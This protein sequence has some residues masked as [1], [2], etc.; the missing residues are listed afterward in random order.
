M[1]IGEPLAIEVSIPVAVVPDTVVRFD[2]LERAVHWLTSIPLLVLLV[3]GSMLYIGPLSG[4]VRRDLLKEIHTVAGLA[5]PVPILLALLLRG[6]N[7][8]LRADLRR[9]AR[10]SRQDG[11]WV[12]SLGRRTY[13]RHPKFNGGQKLFAAVIAGAIPTMLMTGSLMRWPHA[14]SDSSRTGATFVHDWVYLL[15]AVLTVGHILKALAAPGGLKPMVSGRV[16]RAQ[17]RRHWPAWLAEVEPGEDASEAS[18]Q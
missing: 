15:L 6:R 7:R 16:T 18:G 4:I 8:A 10:W 13:A 17:A 2:G 5:L 1:S 12:R 14:F 11:R 9:L 3:T